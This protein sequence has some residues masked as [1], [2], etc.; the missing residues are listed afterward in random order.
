LIEALRN[1][2]PGKKIVLNKRRLIAGTNNIFYN[3]SSWTKGIYF[4]KIFAE[5]TVKTINN[6]PLSIISK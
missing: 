2:Y 1:K 5:S 6:L 4:I 3:T